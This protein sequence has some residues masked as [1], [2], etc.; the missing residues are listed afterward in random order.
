[1]VPGVSSIR[2]TSQ[3]QQSEDPEDAVCQA[4]QSCCAERGKNF[5]GVPA[6]VIY[7]PSIGGNWQGLG[8]IG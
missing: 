2:A 5:S 4:S 7:G 8:Q 3:N 1:M 6:V